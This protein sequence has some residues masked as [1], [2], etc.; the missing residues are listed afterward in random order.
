MH[1]WLHLSPL[2]MLKLKT[3]TH[4][5]FSYLHSKKVPHSREVV[6]SPLKK[7]PHFEFLSGDKRKGCLISTQ[8]SCAEAYFW[9]KQ[10]TLHDFLMGAQ[11]KTQL[12]SGFQHFFK[13]FSFSY[14]Y[15]SPKIC[16]NCQMNFLQ[17]LSR[18]NFS[19]AK[20]Y[21]HSKTQFDLSETCQRRN[22]FEW[23]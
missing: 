23:R 20:N 8:K 17:I 16:L 4:G 2:K 13:L 1:L 15:Y 11:L 14:C 3:Q 19:L 6:L 12:E 10:S 18:D 21:L 7:V 5:R 22:F 9:R